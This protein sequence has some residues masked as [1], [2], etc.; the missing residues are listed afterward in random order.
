MAEVRNHGS[1]SG[2]EFGSREPVLYDG[3]SATLSLLHIHHF[4]AGAVHT[5]RSRDTGVIRS[6]RSRGKT[7]G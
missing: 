4:A 6:K 2:D 3:R 7:K 1:A 5:L